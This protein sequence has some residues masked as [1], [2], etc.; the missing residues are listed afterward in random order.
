MIAFRYRLPALTLPVLVA[1]ACAGPGARPSGCTPGGELAVDS[2]GIPVAT[3][4]TEDGGDRPPSRP[5]EAHADDALEYVF[6]ASRVPGLAAA[7][8]VDGELVWEGYLGLADLDGQI[9]VTA[10]TVFR[11]G[12]VSKA[13]TAVALARLTEAGAIDLDADVRRYVPDFPSKRGVVTPRLLA[14]HL[15][16]IRSYERGDYGAPLRIDRRRF[17]TTSEALEIFEGDTL[18]AAPGERYAY[19]VYGYTLLS[20][21]MEGAAGEPFLDVLDGWLVRPLGLRHTGA[22]STGVPGRAVPY[23]RT[24]RGGASVADSLDLSYKWAGGGLRSTVRDLVA[25]GS[26]LLDPGFLSAEGLE[27]LTTSQRTS[28]G[29]AT[30]VSLGWRLG[31]DSRGRAFIHHAG[32][33]A[34]GRAVILVYP[35]Q[36][37]S[38]AITSNQA[39]VP[40]MI[41][42]TAQVLAEPFL[43]R[44]EGE[45]FVRD[46]LAGEYSLRWTVG[47]RPHEGGLEFAGEEGQGRITLPPALGDWA[48]GLGTSVGEEG[49]VLPALTSGDRVFLPVVTPAGAFFLDLI[50]TP[51][52][53]L[54]GEAAGQYLRVGGAVE[55]SPGPSSE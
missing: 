51:G 48:S 26:A 45:A 15:G 55:A 3:A 22:D 11:I 16:G 44:R 32:S 10:T 5:A 53:G 12:S 27:L 25:V 42:S 39:L 6:C 8:A 20:A 41:E 40:L 46:D 9:P 35:D 24:R 28:D 7:I 43:L 50:R 19:S 31:T 52:G 36:E 13:L 47:D 30:R 33:I 29:E 49:R 37:L 18:L 14:G 1:L 38:V 17:S 4:R 2:P 23:E 34:G 54:A 21:A